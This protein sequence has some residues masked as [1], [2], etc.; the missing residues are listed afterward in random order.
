MLHLHATVGDALA[1]AHVQTAWGRQPGNPIEVLLGGFH[2]PPTQDT[3]FAIIVTVAL[4]LS[5]V[6]WRHWRY[7]ETLLLG[8]GVL[9]PLS[10]SLFSMPRYVFSLFPF[11]VLLALSLSAR[12]LAGSAMLTAM[13]I[14]AGLYAVGWALIVGMV[15]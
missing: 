9:V 6:G 2:V 5:I 11:Y 14:A 10:T 7:A 1:F 13:L 8:G 15:C 3:W 12:P 4:A